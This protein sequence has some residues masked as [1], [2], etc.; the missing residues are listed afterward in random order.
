MKTE[1][2]IRGF[3]MFIYSSSSIIVQTPHSFVSSSASTMFE[4]DSLDLFCRIDVFILSTNILEGENLS[5][6]S[7]FYGV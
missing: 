6:V 7:Y 2:L 1:Y 4:K 5:A 3:L